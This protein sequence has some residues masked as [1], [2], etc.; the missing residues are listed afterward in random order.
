MALK[1][2]NS[3]MQELTDI[4]AHLKTA[5]KAAGLTLADLSARTGIPTRSLVRMEAA[6]PNAPIG[7]IVLVLQS[8]GYGLSIVPTSRPT[9]ESLQS[10]YADEDPALP[11]TAKQ[12]AAR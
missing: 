11:F 7:R 10:L 5:R 6:D 12:N 8:L 3:Q 2:D 9:L 4:G 1:C